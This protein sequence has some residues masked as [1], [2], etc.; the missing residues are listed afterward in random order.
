MTSN[1]SMSRV[2]MLS[3]VNLK[4]ALT[5][6][7]SLIYDPVIGS[8]ELAGRDIPTYAFVKANNVILNLNDSFV[9][10]L[11]KVSSDCGWTKVSSSVPV[12][13]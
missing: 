13:P 1:T 7:G 6:A 3:Y 10:T 12:L 4:T 9:S 8:Y 11:E 2:S 5:W